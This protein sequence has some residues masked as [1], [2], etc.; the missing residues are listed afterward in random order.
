YSPL[1]GTFL[2]FE[3]PVNKNRYVPQEFDYS[4]R[5]S[6]SG[7][8]FGRIYLSTI[9]NPYIDVKFSYVG[10]TERFIFKRDEIPAAII[11]GDYVPGVPASD[12]DYEKKHKLFVPGFA[13]GIQPHVSKNLFINFSFGMDFYS[14]QNEGFSYPVVYDW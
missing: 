8:L 14:F 9:V 6:I 7:T 2:E 11:Y 3:D 12:F 10:V 13:I 4:F 5:N 1:G